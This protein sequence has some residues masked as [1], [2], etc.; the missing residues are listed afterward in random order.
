MFKAELLATISELDLQGSIPVYSVV[1]NVEV[2]VKLSI[3]LSAAFA[4]WSTDASGILFRKI[5][6]IPASW[7]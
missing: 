2:N 5:S 6:S 3:I 1:E 7:K 4:S